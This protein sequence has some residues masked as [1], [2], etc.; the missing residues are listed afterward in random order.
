MAT[1]LAQICADELGIDYREVRVVHGQTGRKI[2]PL[3]S[4]W[5]YRASPESCEFS[6][7][8]NGFSLHVNGV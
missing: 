3:T 7:I 2:A 1:V 4:R 6:L 5:R 8:L